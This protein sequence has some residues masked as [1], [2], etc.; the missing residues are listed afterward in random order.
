MIRKKVVNTYSLVL[1]SFIAADQMYIYLSVY[2]INQQPQ[3]GGLEKA[4]QTCTYYLHS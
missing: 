3:T 2:T 4:S 1:Q